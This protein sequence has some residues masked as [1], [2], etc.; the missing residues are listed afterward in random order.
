[1]LVVNSLRTGIEL[2]SDVGITQN[3]VSHKNGNDPDFYNT[4]WTIQAIRGVLLWLVALFIAVPVAQFYQSP[5]LA[6]IVPVIAFGTVLG[7]FTSVT[8]ELLQKRL[9]IAKL[10]AFETVTVII[11]SAAAVLFA[12]LSPTV[13]AL[14][15]GNLF[16]AAV[17]MIGSYFLLPDVTQRFQLSKRFSSEILHFGKWIF[18]SS[19]LYFLSTNFDRLYLAKAIPLQLLGVYGIARSISEM[20][21][22]MV[23]RLGS[24]VLFPLI[25]SHSQMS[26]DDLRKQ[27][28]PLRAKFLLATATI[29]S[30]FAAT[31]DIPIKLLYDER[32]QAANWMLP[33]LI[34]GSWFSILVYLN[35]STLLGLGKPSYSAASNVFKFTFILIG[36]PL[37]LKVYGLIGCILVLVLADLVR[38]IPI[39][40]G[41]RRQRF[42][43]GTQDLLFTLAAFLFIGLW[44]WMRWI[45]GFGTSFDSLPIEMGSLFGSGRVKLVI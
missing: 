31:A 5:I 24:Y 15:F 1:M 26:R 11:S 39:F 23:L 37:S 22:L 30:L 25:A 6:F 27:L 9:Q 16:A 40:I 38:Y 17:T 18:V 8:R 20:L 28:V 3:I 12:Y 2:L 35:E 44:E 43:F 45:S 13:W 36:L 10:S 19:L 42:S 29:F 4:A 34:I 33:V 14:V 7:G 21:G 32:Y 41:Q